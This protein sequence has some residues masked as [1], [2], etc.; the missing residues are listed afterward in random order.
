VG[1][2]Q[3]ARAEAVHVA[4]DAQRRVDRVAALHADERSDL[5]LLLDAL[6]VVGGER[7]RQRLGIHR[8]HAMDDVDLLE[9]RGD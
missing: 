9:G 7:E 6:D 4:K 3:V 5:P 2:R 1:E 8:D